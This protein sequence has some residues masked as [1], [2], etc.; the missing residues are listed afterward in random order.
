MHAGILGKCVSQSWLHSHSKQ[1]THFTVK[2]WNIAV[3]SNSSQLYR[4]YSDG[5]WEFM[6]PFKSNYSGPTNQLIVFSFVFDNIDCPMGGT[7]L[8]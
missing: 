2:H 8:I 7:H 1:Q 5:D 4:F 3:Y 6:R